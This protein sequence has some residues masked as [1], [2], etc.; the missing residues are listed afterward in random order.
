M[1][2]SG[3][4]ESAPPNPFAASDEREEFFL[5]PVL[6]RAVTFGDFRPGFSRGALTARSF[7]RFALAGFFAGD[8]AAP[9][10]CFLG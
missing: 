5:E 2:S 8:R 1:I 6:P 7:E 10:A 9:R 3:S 4:P